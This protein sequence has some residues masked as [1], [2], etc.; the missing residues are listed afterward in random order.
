MMLK[1]L[2]FVQK[3]LQELSS[4]V[5]LK[6]KKLVYSLRVEHLRHKLAVLSEPVAIWHGDY[7]VPSNS[8]LKRSVRSHRN[9]SGPHPQFVGNDGSSSVGVDRSLFVE[10]I[11]SCVYGVEHDHREAKERS[12]DDIAC[13]TFNK[14]RLYTA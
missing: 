3:L 7:R 1:L 11:P 13:S 4:I 12:V 10:K 8:N 6:T 5:D 14:D 2:W 9:L